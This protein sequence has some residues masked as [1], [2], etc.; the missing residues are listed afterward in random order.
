[1]QK[2]TKETSKT[3]VNAYCTGTVVSGSVF[4]DPGYL[5]LYHSEELNLYYLGFEINCCADIVL[6]K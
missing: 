1:M 3:I 5:L 4:C 6:V 2:Q